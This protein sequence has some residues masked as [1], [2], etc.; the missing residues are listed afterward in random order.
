MRAVILTGV[1]GWR[2][3]T[4][5][6]SCCCFCFPFP[7]LFWRAWRLLLLLRALSRRLLGARA[8]RLWFSRAPSNAAARAGKC[9]R[10]CFARGAT[11][12]PGGWPPRRDR[13][14]PFQRPSPK[15]GRAALDGT[16]R[17]G[18]ASRRRGGGLGGGL[19]PSV[20]ALHCPRRPPPIRP[21]AR[22]PRLLRRGGT[23]ALFSGA[24][25]PES[26]EHLV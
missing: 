11:T 4:G 2:P 15:M 19:T 7:R 21:G 26:A 23:G 5:A 20:P 17:G 24:P 14:A 8:G 16:V 22:P 3:P 12:T 6:C 18:G 1:W 9:R 13:P 10:R 25:G